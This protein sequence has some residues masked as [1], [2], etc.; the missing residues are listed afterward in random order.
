MIDSIW[1]VL[2]LNFVSSIFGAII[3]G[4]LSSYLFYRFSGYSE[5]KALSLQIAKILLEPINKILENIDLL[6]KQLEK[7]AVIQ[8]PNPFDISPVSFVM[9]GK[10]VEA[11]SPELIA[12]LVKVYSYSIMINEFYRKLSD[13]YIGPSAAL[14]GIAESRKELIGTT[15][16]L[17]PKFEEISKDTSKDLNEII[18]LKSSAKNRIFS[19]LV[20][21]LKS[22]NS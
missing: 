8:I 14:S 19:I 2:N 4:T 7:E 22:F 18:S 15:L 3:F 17:F 10:F 21:L 5:R 11:M 13:T 9:Q 6:K 20:N 16:K 1:Y 12:K